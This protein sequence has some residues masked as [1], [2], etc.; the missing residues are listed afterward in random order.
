MGVA[1]ILRA[2]LLQH[3]LPQTLWPLCRGGLCRAVLGMN[4]K[5]HYNAR[6]R[7]ILVLWQAEYHFFGP[8]DYITKLETI[9]KNLQTDSLLLAQGM[10]SSWSSIVHINHLVVIFMGVTWWVWLPGCYI[11]V[12]CNGL[13]RLGNETASRYTEYSE[14]AAIQGF[15]YSME[16]YVSS[17]RTRAFGRYIAGSCCSGVVVKRG[18]TVYQCCYVFHNDYI[19]S[20]ANEGVVIF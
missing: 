7:A 9:C 13:N 11:W 4:G 15:F 5:D 6:H 1:Y 18:S 19:D 10:I 20:Y 3:P 12:F 2:R 14:V 16:V 17:I 8:K